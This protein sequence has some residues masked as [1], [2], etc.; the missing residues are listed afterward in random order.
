[1]IIEKKGSDFRMRFF[2]KVVV[3]V[4]EQ[5]SVSLGLALVAVLGA[6][7][8]AF[9]EDL[10]AASSMHDPFASLAAALAIGIAAFGGAMAQAK[11]ASAALEGIGRNPA[12]KEKIFIPMIVSLALIE[13]LVIYAF[14]VAMVKIKT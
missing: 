1:M 11:A 13:S 6:P 12:A 10:A 4:T 5:N 3:A 14:I 8:F 2:K 7:Q 9:A